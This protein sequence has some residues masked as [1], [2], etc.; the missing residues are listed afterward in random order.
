MMLARSAAAGSWVTMRMVFSS[1]RVELLEQREDLVG[2]LAIE[3]AGGLVG[4]DDG[5]V[6]DDGARDGDALLLPARELPRVVAH[7]VLE[8]DDAERRLRRASAARSLAGS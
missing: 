4:D 7:A 6:V 1:S 3:V 5:R 8:A 2:A